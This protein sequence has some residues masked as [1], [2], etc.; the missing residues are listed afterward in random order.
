MNLLKV[1]FHNGMR[2]TNLRTRQ[3]DIP[4]QVYRWRKPELGFA[5]GMRHMNVN[6]RLIPGEKE[7]S[8][9]AVA[10]DGGRYGRTAA[11]WLQRALPTHCRSAHDSTR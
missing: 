8:E 2:L 9:L 4:G 3:T 6:P 11:D 1:R 5:F 7:Q 10:D